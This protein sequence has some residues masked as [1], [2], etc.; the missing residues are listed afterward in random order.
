MNSPNAADPYMGSYYT[1][2]YMFPPMNQDGAGAWSNGGDPMSFLGGYGQM[3]DQ[4]MSGNNMYGGFDYPF[5]G[6]GFPSG[7]FNTWG[8]APKTGRNDDPHAQYQDPYYNAPP[9]DSYASANSETVESDPSLRNI[10]QGVKGM[11]M[12]DKGDSRE[13]HHSSH[14][15]PPQATGPSG[16]GVGPPKRTTWASIASQ[17]ARPQPQ[18]KT[19]SIP[20]APLNPGRHNMDIGTWDNKPMGGKPNPGQQGGP[21]PAWTG[22][23]GGRSAPPAPYPQQGPGGHQLI[24]SGSSKK[25]SEPVNETLEKLKSE[26]QF[27]PK[28]L[29]VNTSNAR[30]FIIKSYSED[31]IH[32]SI[33]YGIWCS[34]EHGNKR[35]DSAY[36]EREDKG[37]VY[38]FYSVNGSGHFCGM[39][40]MASAVDYHSL[41]DVW[42]QSKWKGEI[43]VKWIYVKDVPNSQLRHIRLE[44]NENKPVTNSRDTQEVPPEKGK[45]VLKI[46]HHYRHVTSIFDDFNHY[47][48]RQTEDDSKKTVSFTFAL[49]SLLVILSSF[50]SSFLF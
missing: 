24:G 18:V 49:H 25:S 44:N 6:W 17:P 32:R 16:N 8:N 21:R 28:E 19:K 46:I 9:R 13:G 20:R 43:K 35:L 37:P 5:G 26:N 10:E 39:A 48:K 29:T 33:K 3:N 36:R 38:L 30:Y 11:S 34:T 22:G 4:Y 7:D 41:R 1:P 31:D 42:A 15:T 50:L 47:E 2:Q 27:N 12:A 14:Q 23:R 40:Q 45:Q